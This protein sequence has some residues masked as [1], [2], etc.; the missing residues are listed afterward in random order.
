MYICS[1]WHIT[2]HLLSHTFER[3]V[4]PAYHETYFEFYLVF[5]FL[6]GFIRF[7]GRWRGLE[8]FSAL[9]IFVIFIW[10]DGALSADELLF[11]VHRR[12]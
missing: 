4:A 7:D 1:F 8:D 3:L 9:R 5:D 12:R 11:R 10:K 2:E 6:L